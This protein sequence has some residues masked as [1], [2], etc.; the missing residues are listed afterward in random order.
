MLSLSISPNQRPSSMAYSQLGSVR[1]P[2]SALLS[3]YSDVSTVRDTM[4]VSSAS[5]S[6]A[7]DSVSLSGVPLPSLEGTPA[8]GIS[9]ASEPHTPA[10]HPSTH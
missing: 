9:S 5:D 7:P 2:E 4:S 10:E 1:A 6:G 8:P 3:L